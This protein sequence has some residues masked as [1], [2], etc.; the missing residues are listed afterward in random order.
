MC[1][2]DSRGGRP[3]NKG[4]SGGPLNVSTTFTLGTKVLTSSDEASNDWNPIRGFPKRVA[5]LDAVAVWWPSQSMRSA[6]L[7][8]VTN[9]VRSSRLRF[10]TQVFRKAEYWENITGN[11]GNPFKGFLSQMNTMAGQD[12]KWRDYLV[13]QHLGQSKIELSNAAWRKIVI[14]WP[15]VVESSG[16]LMIGSLL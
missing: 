2:P 7:T 6:L 10:D 13:R 12:S 3:S 11:S 16:P 5:A 8:T 4:Q 9:S 15:K 14:R 1:W